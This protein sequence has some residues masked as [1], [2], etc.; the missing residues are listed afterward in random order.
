MTPEPA[1]DNPSIVAR[2]SRL[3]L[4]ARGVAA[5]AV[6][7]AALFGA[8]FAVYWMEGD[9]VKA[10]RT[11]ARAYEARAALLELHVYLLQG[12]TAVSQFL[13][14]GAGAYLPAFEADRASVERSLE[15]LASLV[16]D[17]PASAAALRQ[18]QNST[19]E[20]GAARAA[21]P[22]RLLERTRSV[23]AQVEPHLAAMEHAQELRFSRAGYSRDLARQKL[24]R[25]I[26]ICG[27]LGPLGALFVHLLL[28]GRTVRRLQ[29]L[30]ENARRLAHG[31]PLE[32]FALGDDEIAELARQIEDA[33]YFLRERERDLRE[34]EARYRELF[35]QA[36][37]PYEE[38][39]CEG[40]IQRF[41]QA[42]CV[43]LKCPPNRILGRHAWDFLAPDEQ[44]PFRAAM[45]E[46]LA[47][48][49]EPG[50]IQCE[51]FLEDG[52]RIAVEI[53]ET[54]IRDG[55]GQ[56]TG[57]CRSLMDVTERNLAVVAARKVEQYALELR[58]KNEQLGRALEAARSA[59]EAKSRFLAG[60]S[61]E[62]RTP[63]NAIIGFSEL[64]HDGRVGPVSDEQREFLSDILTSAGHLLRLINDI[65]D[66]SKIEAGK[67][68]F[69]PE[70]RPIQ[71][72]AA[73]VCEVVRPLA[74]K[75]NLQLTIDAP[76]ELTAVLDP[77]RFKQVLYNF[78]SNAVKFTPAGGRVS[79]RVTPEGESR[80]RVEVEDTGI[81]IEPSE[82]PLLFK[83]FQQLPH[84]RKAD[85]GTGLGLALTRTIVEA[86]G[87][88]VAVRSQPGHGSVFSAV[89]PL[90][91][92]P[93]LPRV[94]E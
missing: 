28:A 77:S 32:P 7:M 75:K 18:I 36:P 50:P 11:A 38:T 19:R 54:L 46:R 10:E 61:H 63:L 55:S 41:N 66:L 81:G 78:L 20:L 89:L 76:S 26:L 64:I 9:A 57:I 48:S 53:R 68:Q 34:S 5:L 25:V 62:L 43:L 79:V 14:T 29:A 47:G 94:T 51:Y 69:R 39:D 60:I 83:E 23:I 86:Q 84:S 45:I 37:I 52:S 67:M 65:L 73:E 30:E 2:W 90:D 35:D 17:D 49:G 92:T 3:S 72:L 8:L 42:V 56:V 1:R 91:T 44:E 31:L 85:Q 13:A 88:K 82:M 15:R 22:A 71:T 12:E 4:R 27:I 70:R 87:G 59:T 80:F 74:E 58:N 93:S 16:N 21:S 33:A 40:V 24:F 6:P